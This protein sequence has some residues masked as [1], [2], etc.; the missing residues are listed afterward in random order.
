MSWMLDDLQETVDP[1]EDES[2]ITGVRNHIVIVIHEQIKAGTLPNVSDLR[3]VKSAISYMVGGVW[4]LKNPTGSGRFICVGDGAAP[5]QP[6]SDFVIRRQ[7]WEYFGPWEPA[8]A[9]WNQ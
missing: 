5:L 8:P 7:T 6:I 2:G 3:Q 1:S 9:E 4:K